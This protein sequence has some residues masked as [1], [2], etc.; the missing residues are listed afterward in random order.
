[1]FR[2]GVDYSLRSAAITSHR[3]DIDDGQI[4]SGGEV[5]SE[6][7]LSEKERS[8]RAESVIVS[9]LLRS[10][11]PHDIF[12]FLDRLFMRWTPTPTQSSIVDEYID[13]SI[14]EMSRSYA[15][16]TAL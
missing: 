2:H 1:V 11:D 14:S 4:A 6:G 13:A 10:L 9:C 16:R 7:A 12:I 8:T 5:Q 15:G 3:C